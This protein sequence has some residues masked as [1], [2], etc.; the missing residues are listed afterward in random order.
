VTRELPKAYLRVDPDID[1]KHPDNLADFMRLVCSANRQRPRGRF[2]SRITLE[3]IFNKTIVAR[4]YDRGDVRDTEDGR[5]YVLG[6]D[7]WQE[8]DMTVAERVRRTRQ[9]KADALHGRFTAV[10]EPLPA[11]LSA[12]LPTSLS[13]NN[14]LS[15]EDS[16]EDRETERRETVSADLFKVIAWA[17]ELSG[18][19][20]MYRPGSWAWETL[21]PDV[22][23][24]GPEAVVEAMKSGGIQYPDIN[25]LVGV[26][27]NALHPYVKA[28]RT[29]EDPALQAQHAREE[30]AA[31]RRRRRRNQT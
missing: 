5:V 1:Q 26:A 7:E 18:R 15:K 6:W 19:P 25:Q 14:S 17:E 8:G 20:W 29:T 10:T 28:T 27:H 24:F 9:K 4:F 21:A 23:D 13:I 11:P 2:A 31:E 30:A 12:P 3:A 22:R 16:A